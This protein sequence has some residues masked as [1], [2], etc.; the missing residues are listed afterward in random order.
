M[1]F[2]ERLAEHAAR[3]DAVPAL[4]TPRATL[5]YGALAHEAG[6][7]AG[8]LC[9]NGVDGTGIVGVTVRGE[10]DHLVVTLALLVLGAPMVALASREPA[11]SRVRL[12]ARVGV[13]LVLGD[14]PGDAIEGLRFVALAAVRAEAGAAEVA[15]SGR[16]RDPSRPLLYLT[17]SGTTGEP[18]II[19]YAERDL[20]QHAEAH[21]DFSRERVLRP[22]HVE[23][24]N[25]KR[26]R[27][28][29][30]W[31][32]GTCI[33][34]DGAVDAL[35][36]LCARHD[37]TWLELSPIHG[38]SL[39]AAVRAHGPLPARTKV[40][41]G[42]A[43]V[44]IALRRAI[45]AEAT[46]RL[47]V[48]Y[49][50]TETSFVSI[51]GPAMH[52]ARESVGPPTAGAEVEVLRADRARAAPG[53]SGTIRLRTPGMATGYVGDDGATA[54]HFRDGWFEPGDLATL[55]ADGQLVI[56]GRAD[57]M[58]IMNGINIYPVE[59]ERILERHPA[60]ESAAAFPLAS[61]MHG[62]IPVAAVELR[63]GMRCAGGELVAF[64]R[65]ALGMRG[66]RRVE[67]LAALPR[68]P[69]GKV[70]K[71]E[72]AAGFARGEE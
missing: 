24:N 33:L 38:A 72:L 18:K 15:R 5:T 50:T 59:I 2:A 46:P 68:N 36:V 43:R 55:D 23:Y 9:R 44:P 67:V 22:A 69:Q 37:A 71:R 51:A 19:A 21:I 65:D 11:A 8:A 14:Q 12:A 29:T 63:A 53:E 58:M 34:A 3:R 13:R 49:G 54:Q 16:S 17:G 41:I 35:S 4:V 7:L 66:P 64:A 52:D 25:S 61:D 27:L 26:M 60:V 28:Y 57:D 6:R 48:S 31:Q 47:Y 39:L 70:L 62:Q 1:T 45:L 30:L 10:V 40:R 20:A 32:G 56:H 42:G